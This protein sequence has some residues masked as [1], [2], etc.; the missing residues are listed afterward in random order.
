MYNQPLIMRFVFSRRFFILLAA[1]FVPLSLSWNFPELRTMVLAYDIS[2]VLLAVIDYFISRK[3]PEELTIE[4]VF[5]RR[6]AIGDETQIELRVENR[7]RKTFRLQ[8]KDEFP[9][10]MKLSEPREAN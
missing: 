2:L 6:F 10:V 4:R 7:S 1:G 5:S 9:P 8:I 3:L